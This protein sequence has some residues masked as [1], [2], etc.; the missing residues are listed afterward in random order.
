RGRACPC[1]DRRK[2]MTVM[3]L[4]PFGQGQARAARSASCAIAPTFTLLQLAIDARGCYRP[5]F[6]QNNQE[7][8]RVNFAIVDWI[9][10]VAYLA[11][12]VGIGLMGKRLVGN[13]SHYLVAGREL[14]LYVG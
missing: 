2:A 6:A 7:P 13:V 10:V 14:G 1:P 9:I 8:E 11:L 4:R 5:A 12:S 3:V